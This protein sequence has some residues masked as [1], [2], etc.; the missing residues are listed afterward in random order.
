MLETGF[1]ECMYAGIK[2]ISVVRITSRS[3]MSEFMEPELIAELMATVTSSYPLLINT[4]LPSAFELF[5]HKIQKRK[6]IQDTLKFMVGR[7]STFCYLSGCM[8]SL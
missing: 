5:I 8:S 7:V 1:Q 6:H 4:I 2:C 3:C